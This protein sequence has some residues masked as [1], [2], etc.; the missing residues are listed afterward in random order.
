MKGL[1]VAVTRENTDDTAQ[2][3]DAAPWRTKKLVR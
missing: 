2:Q 3:T 1:A